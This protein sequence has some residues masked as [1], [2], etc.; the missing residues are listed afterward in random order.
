MSLKDRIK[1][2]I[3]VNDFISVL[4]F[5]RNQAHVFHWQTNSYAAHM[6]FEG[7]YDGIVELVDSLV[8]SYQGINDIIKLYSNDEKYVYGTDAAT[9]F[10]DLLEFVNTNRTLFIDTDILNI[11]DEIITLIKSTLY[12]LTKLS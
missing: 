11:I 8:E 5:S 10:K 6:A 7:Y 1:N 4:L 9:Y 2:N 12:K 3:G